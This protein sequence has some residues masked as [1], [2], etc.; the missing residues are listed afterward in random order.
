MVFLDLVAATFQGLLELLHYFLKISRYL[1]GDAF[2][3]DGPI[4]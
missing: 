3:Y 1:L 4:T 2:D